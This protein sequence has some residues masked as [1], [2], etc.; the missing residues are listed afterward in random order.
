MERVD[1]CPFCKVD[2][3]GLSESG[4]ESILVVKDINPVTPG[5]RLVVPRDHFESLLELTPTLAE[6]LFQV[7]VEV[8]RNAVSAGA[9]GFNLGI[10]DGVAAG[11]SVHHVHIHVIPRH[12]GDVKDPFGGVR[13]VIATR[14]RYCEERVS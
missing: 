12:L 11:Q 3:Q 5:H 7:A 9:D 10:N 1:T 8:A 13:G 2:F 14:Q 6:E 4:R